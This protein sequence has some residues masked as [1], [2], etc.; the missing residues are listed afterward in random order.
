MMDQQSVSVIQRTKRREKM[1]IH[2]SSLK[3]RKTMANWQ[4]I[5][6][7][8][9]EIEDPLK[10]MD[11]DSTNDILHDS[12]YDAEIF[13]G[14]LHAHF[15]VEVYTHSEGEGIQGYQYVVWVNTNTCT[16]DS[17]YIPDLPSYLM[18]M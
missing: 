4:Y 15:S 18:F 14:K 12:G 16:C 5:H 10:H 1:S 13:L 11:G 8:W 7:T 2:L 17:V 6:G 9:K 3:R